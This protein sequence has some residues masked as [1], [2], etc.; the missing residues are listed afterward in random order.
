MVSRPHTDQASPAMTD[1]TNPTTFRTLARAIDLLAAY[2]EGSIPAPVGIDLP[3]L[4][5]EHLAYIAT[6]PG[7]TDVAVWASTFR[8]TRANILA[9]RA[10]LDHHP[11]TVSVADVI[12]A[13][14]VA[15]RMFAGL[16]TWLDSSPALAS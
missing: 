12:A 4:T 15:E 14:E 1:R 5:P 6:P 13:N 7:R 16:A 2:G 10:T 11:E 8:D 9:M 3:S